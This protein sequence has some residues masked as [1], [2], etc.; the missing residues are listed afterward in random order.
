MPEHGGD[1]H[2]CS[3]GSPSQNRGSARIC[4]ARAL[5]LR[6]VKERGKI[7]KTVQAANMGTVCI[8]VCS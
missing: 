7:L 5:M 2:F 8:S 1:D 6:A 4:R 3:A